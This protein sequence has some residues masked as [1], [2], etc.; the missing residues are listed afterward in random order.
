MSFWVHNAGTNEDHLAPTVDLQVVA[1]KNICSGQIH[2][3][4]ALE[5][6][7]KSYI[8]RKDI[9]TIAGMKAYEAASKS[10]NFEGEVTVWNAQFEPH[11]KNMAKIIEVALQRRSNILQQVS[12]HT[13][14][15]RPARLEATQMAM[16]QC[17]SYAE[18]LEEKENWLLTMPL[19]E[20]HWRNKTIQLPFAICKLL[21]ARIQET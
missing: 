4:G 5:Y 13:T 19:G 10:M 16:P 9:A 7:C 15:G 2:E 20:V 11:V 21:V 18:F 12:Q 17:L 3:N 6:F 8:N 14:I 1:G